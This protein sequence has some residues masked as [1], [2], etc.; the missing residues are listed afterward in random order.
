MKF[1][2]N[3]ANLYLVERWTYDNNSTVIVGGFSEYQEAEDYKDAC[4]QE[5]RDKVP[6]DGQEDVVFNVTMTTFYG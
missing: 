2:K 5:W 1:P 3:R 6:Y 4:M